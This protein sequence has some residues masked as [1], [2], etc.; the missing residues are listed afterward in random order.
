MNRLFYRSMDNLTG[1][2]YGRG[3]ECE[4]GYQ[5]VV[6]ECENIM[7]P[8]NAFLN[9]SSSG[10]FSWNCERGYIKRDAE[11]QYIK[12]PLNGYLSDSSHQGN[13]A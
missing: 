3:Y 8:T 1:S 5:L 12:I 2:A 11:C 10:A 4:R 13:D 7:I 9:S 6:N